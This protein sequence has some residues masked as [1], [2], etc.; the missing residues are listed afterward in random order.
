VA[1]E[2]Q[3]AVQGNLTRY[4]KVLVA[5]LGDRSALSAAQ[6]Q[7]LKML[8]SS[9][10]ISD[11]KAEILEQVAIAERSLRLPSI[12]QKAVIIDQPSS[13]VVVAVSPVDENSRMTETATFFV[14]KLGDRISLE[15][16]KIPGG[17]QMGSLLG[18]GR[19]NEQ[20]KHHVQVP[21]FWMGKYPVTQAQW[22]FVALLP[23]EK[24]E[25]EAN[26]SRFKGDNRPVEMV[27]WYQALE[28]CQRLSRQTVND[29]CLPSEAE[30]ECACWAK[31]LTDFYFGDDLT[32]ELANYNRKVGRTTD[33]G[34]YSPNTFDLYDMHGNIWEWCQDRWYNSYQGMPEDG[35][36]WTSVQ[37]NDY[38]VLRGGSWNFSPKICHSAARYYFN[39]CDRSDVIGFR[40]VGR[41]KTL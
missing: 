31:T 9:L 35:S 29:Y 16:I 6:R 7:E 13:Q 22:R 8:Q 15:M 5:D 28:F 40:V 37:G 2:I 32:P 19:D 4:F 25:L 27:S 11:G 12:A 24:I 17:L 1:I 18:K 21:E 3:Q 33:I 39:P 41:A 23:Q 36:A 10:G 30:W 34:I 14:E 20:P 38:K 26:P